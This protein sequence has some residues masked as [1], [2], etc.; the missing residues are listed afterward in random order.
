MYYVTSL[1]GPEGFF[2]QS[3]R[4]DRPTFLPAAEVLVWKPLSR[5]TSGS[6]VECGVHLPVSREAGARVPADRQ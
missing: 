1:V 2:L 5:R 3:D 6:L 4:V